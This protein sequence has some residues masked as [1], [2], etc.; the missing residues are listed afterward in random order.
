VAS[1]WRIIA[2]ESDEDVVERLLDLAR[3]E[4]VTRFVVGIPRPLADQNR[5]TDQAKR[6]REFIEVLKKSGIETL[7][8]DETL[9]SKVA[10]DQVKEMGGKGKR[11]DLAAAAILQNYLN[12]LPA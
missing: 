3:I 11:D 6:I 5:E 1:P 9:T 12:G 2:N 10:A 4:K 8:A 7:E